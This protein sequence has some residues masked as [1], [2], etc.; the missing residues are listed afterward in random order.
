MNA[1][2]RTLRK[3]Y[4]VSGGLLLDV[5]DEREGD[6]PPGPDNLAS[7]SPWERLKWDIQLYVDGGV[8]LISHASRFC[9]HLDIDSD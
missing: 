3:Q 4:G 8:V 1:R 5:D 9:M 6:A 2:L 7:S